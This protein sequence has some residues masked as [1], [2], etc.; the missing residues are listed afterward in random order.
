M[1]T[2]FGDT[3]DDAR[4]EAIQ[5]FQNDESVRFFVSN[6]QTAGRGLTLT[7]ASNVIYYAN[8]F[9]LESR[10]QS[11]DRCHRIGQHKSVTYVDLLTPSSIDKH[12]VSSLRNK[13][14]LS[15]KT[16]GEQARQWLELS[17]R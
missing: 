17:P 11:E 7:A 8:D 6:P 10:I 12:I 1:V 15:A 5:K 16:L 3:S 4:Q 14:D 2:Y 9:N 13:I